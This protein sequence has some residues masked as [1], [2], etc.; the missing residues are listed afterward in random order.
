MSNQ[1]AESFSYKNLKNH[2]SQKSAEIISEIVHRKISLKSVLD[3]GCGVG[4]WMKKWKER[5]VSVVHGVD[6][7]W[8]KDGKFVVPKKW[9]N[10]H[11]IEKPFNQGR[12]YDLVTCL[13]VAEHIHE[14]YSEIL[15]D[16]L[17][18]HSK[19]ILFSAAVPG[20]GGVH[21]VNEQF[22]SYWVEKFE[23]RGYK[24]YDIVRPQTWNDER[25]KFY[26]S[27]NCLFLSK[28]KKDFRKVAIPDVIHP[29]L[30]KKKTDYKNLSQ[31][32]IIKNIPRYIVQSIKS[33][34]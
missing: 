19:N 32:R 6:A 4:I 2:P 7:K 28:S 18:R 11:N 33:R 23:K 1:T 3:V 14:E 8:V 24:A 13:E 26:Y 25:V 22:Q 27:Q 20:Q 31:R 5:G 34:I 21:H 16:S 10:F 15:V 29:K 17:V 12:K 30:L 9:I